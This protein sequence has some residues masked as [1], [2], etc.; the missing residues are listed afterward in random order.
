MKSN[1]GIYSTQGKHKLVARFSSWWKLAKSLSVIKDI[2]A[3]GE[4]HVTK[5]IGKNN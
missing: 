5:Y 1:L 2:D 3:Y 4:R